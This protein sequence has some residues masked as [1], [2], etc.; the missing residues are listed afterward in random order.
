LIKKRSK[1]ALD[2]PAKALLRWPHL[3]SITKTFFQL[4]TVQGQSLFGAYHLKK[5]LTFAQ[6]ATSKKTT[7]YIYLQ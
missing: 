1:R 2:F 6:Y 7:A 3:L 5:I 4:P